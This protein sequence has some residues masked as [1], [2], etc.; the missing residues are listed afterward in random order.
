MLPRSPAQPPLR[1]VLGFGER[2]NAHMVSRSS[3]VL[4]AAILAFVASASAIMVWD[5]LAQG[6]GR[7]SLA[8]GAERRRRIAEIVVGV[9][10]I[11]IALWLALGMLSRAW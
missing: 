3:V 9:L 11:A 6:V 7:S 1:F 8:T 10:G 5:A 2:D 4:F